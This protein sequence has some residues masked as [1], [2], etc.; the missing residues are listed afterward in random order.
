M[1]AECVVVERPLLAD[2]VEEVG[3]PNDW[4]VARNQARVS[5][6]VSIRVAGAR[7]PARCVAPSTPTGRW[8]FSPCRGN[9]NGVAFSGQLSNVLTHGFD[10]GVFNRT[11]RPGARLV[12]Q[13]VHA[14][15]RP[16][17]TNFSPPNWALYP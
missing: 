14:L 9:S 2:C 13:P 16:G 8:A 5:L 6:N 3:E 10:A 17:D 15:P 11:W 4:G 1:F 7:R 12:M